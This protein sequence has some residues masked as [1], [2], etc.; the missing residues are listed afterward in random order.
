[1]KEEKE[2]KATNIER[3]ELK[4][5]SKKVLG[6]SELI[7]EVLSV[8]ETNN[9]IDQLNLIRIGNDLFHLLDKYNLSWIESF[10]VMASM[11]SSIIDMYINKLNSINLDSN[12]KKNLLEIYE[13]YRYKFNKKCHL[14]TGI[15]ALT[16]GILGGKI[17]GFGSNPL[18]KTSSNLKKRFEV[19][20]K[21][22]FKCIYCGRKAPEVSLELEH[23]NPKSNGGSDDF[24]NLAPACW[25]CN[26]G[27]GSTL[28]NEV[29]KDGKE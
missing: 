1:M 2:E 13:S 19:L 4:D 11:S 15:N 3:E 7:E 26:R 8:I 23:I 12:E 20:K 27:K 22:G 6:Q 5:I 17:Y 28:L 9:N 21:Y 10:I 14:L 24:D 18:F 29:I 16:D 25:E